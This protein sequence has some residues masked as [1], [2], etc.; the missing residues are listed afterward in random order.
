MLGTIT[1]KGV[2]VSLAQVLRIIN[3]RIEVLKDCDH[4]IG[5]SYFLKVENE[6]DLKKVFF[7]NIIPLL[8][9]YFYGD[10]EKIQMVLGE[11]F[12]KTVNSSDILFANGKPYEDAPE[13]LYRIQDNSGSFDLLE[14]LKKM[15]IPLDIPVDGNSGE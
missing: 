10:N 13:L 6:K 2:R 9:E 1:I 8:Q 15:N 4:L 11:G 5:H 14:A 7:D 12:V 3:D